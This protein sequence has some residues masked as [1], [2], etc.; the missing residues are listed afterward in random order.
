MEAK[1]LLQNL[2]KKLNKLK[3]IKDKKAKKEILL[4]YFSRL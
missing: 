4:R 3:H 2:E 1:K